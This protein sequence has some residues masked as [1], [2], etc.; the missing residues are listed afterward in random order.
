MRSRL[1]LET[2]PENQILWEKGAECH[3]A[4]GRL[5]NSWE[6]SVW[7]EKWS[8]TGIVVGS[9]RSSLVRVSVSRPIVTS[10][11]VYLAVYSR[12]RRP[13]NL[14]PTVFRVLTEQWL[15]SSSDIRMSSMVISALSIC[16]R[17][18]TSLFFC[19][20]IYFLR[21]LSPWM[22]LTW[23][24]ASWDNNLASREGNKSKLLCSSVSPCT[25]ERR[26]ERVDLFSIIPLMDPVTFSVWATFRLS[27]A[28]SVQEDDA[29]PFEA[30]VVPV[31][32]YVW[33]KRS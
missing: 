27:L 10:L 7:K 3:H 16:Q 17:T 29:T 18:K 12:A 9:L 31:C 20:A 28:V 15:K 2:F 22:T 32:Q 13:F 8:E 26:R 19:L 1:R 14:V 25:L 6:G 4:D 11:N 21:I 33:R 24:T 5:W 30:N 23:T